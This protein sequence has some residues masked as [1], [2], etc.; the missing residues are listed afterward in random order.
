MYRFS[1][2]H[3]SGC[4]AQLVLHM[5]RSHESHPIG[6][7]RATPLSSAAAGSSDTSSRAQRCILWADDFPAIPLLNLKYKSGT[8]QAWFPR[9]QSIRYR[10]QVWVPRGLRRVARAW[11]GRGAG[12]PAAASPP[13][14]SQG[15][16]LP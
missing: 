13:W 3:E 11:R 9:A 7:V 4:A 5:Y 2:M 12:A 10:V 1:E 14:V 15:P 6:G 16:R 8:V